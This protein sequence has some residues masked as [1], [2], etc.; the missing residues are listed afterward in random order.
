MNGAKNRVED[1]VDTWCQVGTVFEGEL[2]T[3]KTENQILLKQ[4]DEQ[5]TLLKELK[6]TSR[7]L[8]AQRINHCSS[9]NNDLNSENQEQQNEENEREEEKSPRKEAHENINNNVHNSSKN[10]N[11]GVH[12]DYRVVLQKCHDD[13][14]PK[15]AEKTLTVIKNGLLDPKRP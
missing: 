1:L 10:P 2:L 14:W 12:N 6:N 13:E 5:Q 7:L 8:L 3:V 9:P 4:L 11:Q 15:T